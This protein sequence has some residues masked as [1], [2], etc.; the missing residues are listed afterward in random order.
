MKSSKH[1]YDWFDSWPQ[2]SAETLKFT[3]HAFDFGLNGDGGASCVG[4][5]STDATACGTISNSH[6]AFATVPGDT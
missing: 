1:T 2:A 4:Y 3:N 6:V 5:S